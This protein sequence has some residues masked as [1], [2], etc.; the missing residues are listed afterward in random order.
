MMGLTIDYLKLRQGE[1]QLSLKHGPI[2]STIFSCSP[3]VPV[4]KVVLSTNFRRMRVAVPQ[5][6]SA[7][8]S[9]V[10]EVSIF[11]PDAEGQVFQNV[12]QQLRLCLQ[13]KFFLFQ[14]GE[15]TAD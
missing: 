2:V 15:V 3:G 13:F 9:D 5:S 7:I 14:S 8:A 4:L 12:F 10:I 11:D 1:A 6:E